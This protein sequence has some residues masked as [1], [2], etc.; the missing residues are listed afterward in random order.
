MPS[1]MGVELAR[2]G[3]W[4]LSTGPRTFTLE[5]FADAV[6]ASIDPEFGAPRIRPGHTDPRFDGEPA[7]GRVENM[8]VIGDRLVGDLVDL[9]GWLAAAEGRAAYPD[10]SIEGYSNVTS[11][12]GKKYRLVLSRLALLGVTPPAMDGLAD[13]PGAIAAGALPIAASS[14]AMGLSDATAPQ[15]PQAPRRVGPSSSGTE[16]LRGVADMPDLAALRTRLG[17]ADD[18]SDDEVLA[19][20][21]AAVPGPTATAAPAPG[22]PP[23][24]DPATATATPGQ[25]PATAVTPTPPVT[26]TATPTADADGSVRI[27]QAVLDEL[28]ANAAM[29]VAAARRQAKDDEDGFIARH[30]AR[31]GPASNP[32]AARLEQSWRREYQRNPGEAEALAASHAVVMPV[33]E[34]LGHED[35]ADEPGGID[36]DGFER[37]LST[38][39]A[40]S[41][42]TRDGK[43]GA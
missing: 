3:T 32:K 12:T 39:V 43:A 9:P 42:A 20:A 19:A 24:A 28:Q 15:P 13:L 25:V 1:W 41:R 21:L 31:L 22:A 26:P 18:V 6:A 38:D 36:W 40:A 5:D 10:R 4:D 14:S 37:G 2:V 34:A 27:S 29:G 33:T 7:L 35:G 16:P 23:A 30:R 8:R 17:L 11:T